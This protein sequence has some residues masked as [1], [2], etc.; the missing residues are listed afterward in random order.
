MLSQNTDAQLLFALGLFTLHVS[1]II[2]NCVCYFITTRVR[3]SV[4]AELVIISIYWNYNNRVTV[5]N[6]YFTNK[7]DN[8][9]ET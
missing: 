7:N 4:T 2:L 9:Q 3:Q 6:A 8:I 1:D 5:I